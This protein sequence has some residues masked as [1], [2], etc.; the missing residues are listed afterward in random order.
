MHHRTYLIVGIITVL[1]FAGTFW[2]VQTRTAQTL[3]PRACSQIA[4][5]CPDGSAV[6]RTGPNCAFAPCPGGATTTDSSGGTPPFNSGVLGTVLL[7]PTCPVMRN[8]PDPA[9]ADKPYQTTIT[10]SRA[11]RTAVFASGTSAADGTFHL[12]LPPGDYTL[13][14]GGGKMLPR[15]NPVS[16]TVAPGAYKNADISCDT[17]IR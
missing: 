17:G 16:I 1:A 3:A 14:A 10:V 12:S 15:C 5:L 4:K 8:P 2:F 6:L 7:G 13:S 11:G 9:C